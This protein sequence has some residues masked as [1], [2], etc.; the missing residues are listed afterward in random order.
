MVSYSLQIEQNGF[1]V[2]RALLS[3]DAYPRT[4]QRQTRLQARQASV[5]Y[6]DNNKSYSNGDDDNTNNRD[7]QGGGGRREE[8]VLEEGGGGKK[9]AVVSV[10]SQP[11]GAFRQ[12]KQRE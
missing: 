11:V 2:K 8:R 7:N 12:D 9:K 5:C 4:H 6:N 1:V 3:V 10:V